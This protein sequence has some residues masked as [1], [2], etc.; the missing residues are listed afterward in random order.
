MLTSPSGSRGLSS[1]AGA[2]SA[3]TGPSTWTP[4]PPSRRSYLA[5]KMFLIRNNALRFMISMEAMEWWCLIK[6]V[7]LRVSFR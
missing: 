4:G 1:A 3:A 2:A 6:T 5:L 7:N